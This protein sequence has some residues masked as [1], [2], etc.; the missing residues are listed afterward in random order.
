VNGIHPYAHVATAEGLVAAENICGGSTEIDYRVIPNVVYTDPEL[1]WTG[2]TEEEAVEQNIEYE[3]AVFPLSSNA[4][5]LCENYAEGLI[6][7]I[8][9]KKHKE[10]LGVHILAPHAGELIGEAVLALKL[11][12]TADELVEMIHAHPTISEIYA[13]A[14]Y[15][16]LGK[17]LHS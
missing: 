12:A 16:F 2:I 9:G 11:E 17:G 1:A 7:M 14:A 8:A 3:T 6:K 4:K 13:E 15:H 10:I 5:A